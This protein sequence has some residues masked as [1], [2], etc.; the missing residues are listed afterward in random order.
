VVKPLNLCGQMQAVEGKLGSPC[1]ALTVMIQENL[2]NETLHLL[3]QA[4]EIPGSISG[5]SSF[6]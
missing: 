5:S 1:T 4:L 6:S 3:I 2:E